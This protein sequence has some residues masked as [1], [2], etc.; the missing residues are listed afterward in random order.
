MYPPF[1]S[2]LKTERRYYV[3]YILCYVI[4]LYVML[5]VDTLKDSW[6]CS[7]LFTSIQPKRKIVYNRNKLK[8][9]TSCAGNWFTDHNE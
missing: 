7:N 6:I 9:S 5:Y 8:L 1:I 4:I 3:C 2:M